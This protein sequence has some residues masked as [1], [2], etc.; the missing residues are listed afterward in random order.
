[1]AVIDGA[2]D[3]VLTGWILRSRL[4]HSS[5]ARRKWLGVAVRTS[6]KVVVILKALR[7]ARV[8]DVTKTPPEILVRPD[9]KMA[10][11]YVLC[12]SSAKVAVIRTSDWQVDTLIDAGKCVEGL[13]WAIYSLSATL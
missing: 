9:G 6:N 10:M 4:W 11:A 7:V 12:D 3:S 5:S 1:M 8:I 2:T 13:A